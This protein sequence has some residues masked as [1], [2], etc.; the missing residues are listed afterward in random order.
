MQTKKMLFIAIAFVAFSF[1]ANAQDKTPEP[2]PFVMHTM[3]LGRTVE[4]FRINVDSLLKVFKE[5]ILDKDPYFLS[6]KIAMHWWGHDSREVVQMCE[7]KSFSDM[8]AAFQKQN[9]LLRD[10]VKSHEE[11]GKLWLAAFF[12]PE[13]HSDEIYR[14]VE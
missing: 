2:K 9:N 1:N 10:Y 3:Y 11:F 12:Q 4:T 8:E 13:H 7:L 14:V 5:N 6:S